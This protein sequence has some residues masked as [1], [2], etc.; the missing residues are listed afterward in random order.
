MVSPN[1]GCGLMLAPGTRYKGG[2]NARD[3]TF[4]QPFILWALPLALL[5]V[6]IHLL[7]RMRHRSMPWAAM[8]FLLS[9]NRSSTR[10]AQLRQILILCCRVLALAALILMLARPVAGGWVG[11]MLAPAPDVIMILLDR[12]ASMEFRETGSE[13]T[14]R[15]RAIKMLAEAAHPFEEKSRLIF[16]ENAVR[17]PQE[18]AT[19][20]AIPALSL[21]SATHTA[22]DIPAMLQGALDWLMENRTGDA[23]IWIASDLQR[24]NWSPESD[25]WKGLASKLAALPQ[26][27]R[28]RLLALTESATANASVAVRDVTRRRRGEDAELDLTLDI[29][30]GLGASGAVPLTLTVDGGRSSLDLPMEGQSLRFHH[31][32]NLGASAKVFEAGGWGKV[33][34]PADGNPLDNTS[35]FTYGAEVFLKAALVGADAFSRRCL[36][37]AVAPSPKAMRQACEVVASS[38]FG[39]VSLQDIALLIWQEA[40]DPA[41]REESR[42]RLRTFVEDGGALIFFPTDQPDPHPFLNAGWGEIQKAEADRPFRVARWEENDGPLVRTDEGHAL[43]IAD[44]RIQQR[45]AIVGEKNALAWFEDGQPFLTRRALGKGW[46]F[47]CATLPNR[48]WSNLGSGP[49]LVPMMQRLLN[50]GGKRLSMASPVACGEWGNANPAE[51]WLCVDSEKSKDFHWQAGVYRC[52]DRWL[53]VN[54]PAIE[55]EMETLETPV[56]RALFGEVPVRMFEEPAGQTSQLTGEMWRIFLLTMLALLFAEGILILPARQPKADPVT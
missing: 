3:M 48:E 29:Q 56:A 28:V 40:L 15:Q 6:V 22:A 34:L 36:Q 41:T 10:H 20:D 53:A 25:R 19:A 38:Q 44:L 11:W 1:P 30:R 9:A 49:V 21:S 50:T 7:N 51:R 4:L 42:Q 32:V 46:V 8:A 45:R 16:M 12:S 39:S 27:V 2:G 37:L 55:D 47:F 18:I 14:K 13:G 54:R 43:P 35:Y 23:E 31:K 5:P 52:G 24:S 26:G 17:V 33:E